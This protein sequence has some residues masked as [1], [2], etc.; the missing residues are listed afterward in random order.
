MQAYDSGAQT[1]IFEPEATQHSERRPADLEV[2][3]KVGA[4]CRRVR[5]SGK[6]VRPLR[7]DTF[8]PHL[9]GMGEDGWAVAFQVLIEPH[10]LLASVEFEHEDAALG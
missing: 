1:D 2:A 6:A 5:V 7:H 3:A 8:Q 4:Y 10:A 9:A